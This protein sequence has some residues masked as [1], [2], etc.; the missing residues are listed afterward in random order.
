MGDKK[1]VIY[2]EKAYRIV[3]TTKDELGIAEESN[4]LGNNYYKLGMKE[5]AR[6]FLLNSFNI[7]CIRV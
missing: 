2:L 4:T 1:S 3:D 5:K 7:A 6:K